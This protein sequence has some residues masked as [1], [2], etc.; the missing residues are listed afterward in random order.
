[1]LADLEKTVFETPAMGPALS[2]NDS[3]ATNR[4][5][6]ETIEEDAFP[7]YIRVR[8]KLGFSETMPRR[9]RFAPARRLLPNHYFFCSSVA[10]LESGSI[11]HSSHASQQ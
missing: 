10:I 11:T 5:K 8:R 1:M 3:G 6:V 7:D 4:R 9:P 2:P